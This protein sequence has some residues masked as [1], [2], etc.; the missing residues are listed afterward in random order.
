ME[1]LVDFVFVKELDFSL[2]ILNEVVILTFT[3][4]LIQN[5]LPDLFSN[6]ESFGCLKTSVNV[7]TLLIKSYAISSNRMIVQIH[8]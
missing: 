6:K 5:V 1:D 2:V 4:K 3:I 8:P 7:V